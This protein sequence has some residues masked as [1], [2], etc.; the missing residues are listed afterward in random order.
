MSCSVVA[1]LVSADGQPS[2][3][4]RLVLIYIGTTPYLGFLLS[5]YEYQSNTLTIYPL[6]TI[7]QMDGN[8][9]K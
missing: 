1:Q 7:A 5:S 4:Y 9:S 8:A 2:K 6:A 3:C